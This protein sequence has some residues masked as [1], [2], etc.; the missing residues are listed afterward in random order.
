MAGPYDEPYREI[1]GELDDELDGDAPADDDDHFEE[2]SRASAYDQFPDDPR[3][4][5]DDPLSSAYATDDAVLVEQLRQDGFSGPGFHLFIQQLIET[6]YAVLR[7]WIIDGSIEQKCAK[8]GYPV[9]T[10]HHSARDQYSSDLA[11]DTAIAAAE[12]FT[13]VGLR[14]GRWSPDRGASLMTYYIGACIRSFPTV[15]RSWY[16][17]RT[18]WA[19]TDLVGQLGE[20][21]SGE[22]NQDRVLQELFVNSTLSKLRELNRPAAVALSLKMDGCSTTEIAAQLNC[23]RSKAER[24]VR[25]ART[26]CKEILR[27]QEGNR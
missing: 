20:Y 22:L 18:R 4:L 15:Y 16:R 12:L 11:A 3:A 25:Q 19:A 23:S 10:L 7:S 24:L 8:A 6:G 13:K 2:D 5:A 14:Q 9:G 1:D 27:D 26:L 21:E 17:R